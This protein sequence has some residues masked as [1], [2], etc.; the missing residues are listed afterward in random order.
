MKSWHLTDIQAMQQRYRAMFINSLSGFKSANLVGTVSAQG[1]ENLCIVSSV[2]HIG[3]DPALMGMITRPQ[4]VRRDTVENIKATG[5]YTLNH[6]NPQIVRAAHQTSARYDADVSE[7]T[8]T[9][10]TASYEQDFK[11]PFVAQSKVRM[12]LEVEEIKL[13]EINQTELIIG[14]IVLVQTDETA[15]E[16]DGSLDIERLDS[17]AISGLDRYHS[18]QKIT[19]LTYAKPD[20]SP[21][22][23]QFPEND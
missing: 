8:E 20:S 5:F 16:P 12:G 11:A 22:E 23:L 3:A 13:L 7:F 18:T 10:L 2:F 17:V 19:R 1:V 14:R 4:T 15:L 21:E 9:G 6:V